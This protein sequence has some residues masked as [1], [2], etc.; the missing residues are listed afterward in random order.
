MRALHLM[1]D[2]V[3]TRDFINDTRKLGVDNHDFL[4]YTESLHGKKFVQPGANVFLF[5]YGT[6]AYNA[7]L[8]QLGKEY[9]H[10]FVHWLSYEA[11]DAVINAP[12]HV[13][14][15]AFFWGNDFAEPT[16]FYKSRVFEP[17]TLAYYDGVKQSS[18]IKWRNNPR[19]RYALNPA[20]LLKTIRNKALGAKGTQRLYEQKKKAVARLDY[21]L[22]F[23][24]HDLD[25][26]NV[27]TPT[28]ALL[29]PFFYAAGYQEAAALPLNQR[30]A[31]KILVGNSASS[32][33]NHLDVLKRLADAGLPEN[34]NVVLPLSYG[35]QQYAQRVIQQ[36]REW[37]RDKLIP[38]TEFMPRDAYFTMLSETNSAIFN[39]KRTQALG[40][41]NAML[42]MGKKVFLNT[43]CPVYKFY[44]EKGFD[45]YD[46]EQVYADPTK[47]FEALEETKA[48]HNRRMLEQYFSESTRLTL[49]QDLLNFRNV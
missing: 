48:M 46:V 42:A 3:F 49:M 45:V 9:T 21:F 6:P 22:H 37:L 33:N 15:G 23:N 34:V 32:T 14:T 25:W 40:N 43:S 44:V 7:K 47:A 27:Q 35:D 17:L 10:L 41:I 8:Q 26:V 11:G 39:V 28:K 36:G 30:P 16:S 13:K 12:P 31:K 38:L 5:G 1:A 20:W 19:W 4:V 2:H 24:P 29:V 18:K